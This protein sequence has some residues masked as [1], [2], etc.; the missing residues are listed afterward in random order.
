MLGSF[1]TMNCKAPVPEFLVN[2][3]NSTT[4]RGQYPNAPAQASL[5]IAFSV[6]FTSVATQLTVAPVASPARYQ[7]LDPP[8]AATMAV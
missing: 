5:V 3:Q 7:A 8:L 6:E 2:A 1:A 4:S